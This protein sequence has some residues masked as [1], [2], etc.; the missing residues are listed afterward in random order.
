M[1]NPHTDNHAQTSHGAHPR[2]GFNLSVLL[3]PLLLLIGLIYY[4]VPGSAPQR[5]NEDD[6]AKAVAARIQKVGTVAMGDANRPLRSGEEVYKAQC[7]AC[8]TAGVAGAPKFGDAGA[9]APRLGTG[10]AALLNSSLKG[11]NAMGPQGGGEFNDFEIGRAVV[12]MAN[13][14]GGKFAEPAAP[15]PAAAT[16]A[17]GAA[18]AP[19]PAPA[20]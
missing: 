1:S 3:V 9:W 11:K 8:H 6:R 7:T 19:A 5:I 4:F 20:K 17:A 15:A 14:A 18:A 12:Y 2:K 10:Y 16:P 13:A